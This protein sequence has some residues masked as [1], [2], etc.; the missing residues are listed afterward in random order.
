MT[1]QLLMNNNLVLISVKPKYA[2]KILIGEKT[3]ELRKSSPLRAKKGTNLLIYVTSPVKEL[4]GICKIE[5]IYKSTPIDLWNK[6][7]NSTGVSYEEFFEYYK[8]TENA[9]GIE[10]GNII[11][12]QDKSIKLDAL[13]SMIQ[14][15]APPQTYKYFDKLQFVPFFFL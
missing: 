13:K 11:D 9:Y 8:D 3:V 4:R 7:G 5:N 1:N 6:M 10:L 14:G 12:L 2:E 15:F